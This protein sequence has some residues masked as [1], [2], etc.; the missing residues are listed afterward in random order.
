MAGNGISGS[1]T[2]EQVQFV[3]DNKQENP[4]SSEKLLRRNP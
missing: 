2:R 3:T 4:N 1:I